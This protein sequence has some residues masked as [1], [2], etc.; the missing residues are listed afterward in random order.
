MLLLQRVSLL[1][2]CSLFL[3]TLMMSVFNQEF[4]S[5]WCPT[6]GPFHAFW[7]HAALTL[8]CSVPYFWWLHVF[9][10]WS[11]DPMTLL[12]PM[13]RLV[14]LN[15]WSWWHLS[16]A[17]CVAVLMQR[18]KLDPL[19]SWSLATIVMDLAYG[20]YWVAR[21]Q[22]ITIWTTFII[23]ARCINLG[24]CSLQ[25]AFCYYPWPLLISGHVHS[26][27]SCDRASVM[28]RNVLTLVSA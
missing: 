19:L 27:S 17:R 23:A 24:L 26:T 18:P 21:I 25:P 14:T 15:V 10:W 12:R 2:S 6:L 7:H 8:Y 11:K 4:L 22:K 3:Y 13:L 1:G 5:L 20:V 16:C 28:C 9:V